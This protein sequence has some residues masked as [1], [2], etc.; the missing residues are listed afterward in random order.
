MASM[1]LGIILLFAGKASAANFDC[2][3]AKAADEKAICLDCTLAR[4]DVEIAR[5]YEGGPY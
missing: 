4:K 5:L 2:T 3:V 1:L